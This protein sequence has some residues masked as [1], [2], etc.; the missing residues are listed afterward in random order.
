MEIRGT[1]LD[2]ESMAS[3]FDERI[4][5]RYWSIYHCNKLSSKLVQLC[6]DTGRELDQDKKCYQVEEEL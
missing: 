1:L 2:L 6:F 5:Y 4:C 3:D